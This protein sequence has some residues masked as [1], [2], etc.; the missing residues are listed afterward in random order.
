M[1]LF[2]ILGPVMVG[3]SSSHTAGA[4]KIGLVARRL[5]GDAP[6]Q[7]HILLHGSFASTGNGHGTDRALVADLLGMEPDDLRIPKSLELAEDAGMHVRFG[8]VHLRGA[9][10]NT[11]SLSLKSK[12]GRELQ[13]VASSLG[14]GRIQVCQI[15]GVTTNF[16]GEYNTLVVHNQDQPGYVAL[17]ATVLAQHNVNIATMQVFRETSGSFAVMVVECDQPIP[18]DV[19]ESLEPVHGILKVSYMNVEG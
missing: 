14:G 1:N 4:V 11:A 2:D 9:H 8:S 3:P 17:V 5:L 12:N 6:V 15:D 19:V 13:M 16:S 7:A 18:R 10:P